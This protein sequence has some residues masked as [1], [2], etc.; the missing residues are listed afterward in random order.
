MPAQAAI[1]VSSVDGTD[2][3]SGPAALFDFDSGP[4][5]EWNGAIFTDSVSGGRAQ[6]LGSTGGYASVGVTTNGGSVNPAMF[7]L[8]GFDSITEISFLWGSIDTYNTIEF[9]DGDG[10]SLGIYTGGSAGIAPANGNQTDGASNRVVTFTIDG[11]TSTELAALKFSSDNNSFEFDNLNVVSGAVPEPATW[12]MMIAGFGL[13]G[14]A[15]RRRSTNVAFAR[16]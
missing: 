11:A 8:S 4:I 14:G 2:P 13:V 16:A 7:D 12:A 3:Y 9:L 1:S 5:A 6:P 10:M 15:M